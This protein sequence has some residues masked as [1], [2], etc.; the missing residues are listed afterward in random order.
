MT[1]FSVGYDHPDMD[2]KTLLDV[3]ARL[4]CTLMD[5]RSVPTSRIPGF[6]QAAL[7]KALGAKYVWKGDTLGGRVPKGTKLPGVKDLVKAANGPNV[8][9]MCK[10]HAAGDCHRHYMVAMPLRDEHKIDVQHLVWSGNEWHVFSASAFRAMMD[11]DYR[12]V[13]PLEKFLKMKK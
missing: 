13:I 3:L 10:E 8:M 1:I 9:L 7:K 4:D 2:Q 11:D 6:S 5:V 12:G